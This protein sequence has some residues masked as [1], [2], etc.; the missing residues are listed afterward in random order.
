[1]ALR[2]GV[3]GSA[4]TPT[5]D[6]DR[7]L[8]LPVFSSAIAS[9]VTTSRSGHRLPRARSQLALTFA[10]HPILGNIYVDCLRQLFRLVCAYGAKS[11]LV[12]IRRLKERVHCPPRARLLQAAFF[13][14]A[15]V[16]E[17]ER[18]VHCMTRCGGA[19]CVECRRRGQMRVRRSNRDDGRGCSAKCPRGSHREEV[20][21]DKTCR[22]YVRG[23]ALRGA[24]AGACLGP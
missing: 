12:K 4:A 22:S 16:A 15:P 10:P 7:L 8:G 9:Y 3:S 5:P 2:G 1:M 24:G 13:F 14:W 11:P 19:A 20:R 23:I 17:G 6:L 21:S 18:D